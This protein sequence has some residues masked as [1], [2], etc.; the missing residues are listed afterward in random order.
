MT[1]ATD[2]QATPVFTGWHMFGCLAAF[3][4]TIIAVNITMAV[5]AA[6]SWTGLIVKNSYVASQNFNTQL[7]AAKVQSASGV[8]SE[9]AL[10]DG[11]LTFTVRNAE[12]S[13]ILPKQAL[14]WIGRPA[15]EQQDRTVTASCTELGICT[16]PAALASGP[17]AV[18]I[19]ALLP[20]GAYRRDIRI[21]MS[22]NGNARV[23]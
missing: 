17:W 8:H 2:K 6:G 22:A 23:E 16:A 15:F 21:N 10:A 14:V 7:E 4:G 1:S 5:F 18:R 12:G 11:M 3:F 20:N 9:V 13:A 19:E